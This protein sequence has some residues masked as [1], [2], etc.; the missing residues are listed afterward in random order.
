[1]PLVPF[2]SFL[3]SS[4]LEIGITWNMLMYLCL[5]MKHFTTLGDLKISGSNSTV[6]QYFPL[7]CISIVS[8]TVI[9]Y[10][11]LKAYSA[12]A[13]S[14][15]LSDSH[16]VFSWLISTSGSISIMYSLRWFAFL[17]MPILRS[18]IR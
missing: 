7:I 16:S 17:H 15:E 9:F 2:L 13:H 10:F 11:A 4:S 8:E 14:N 12:V 1:M 5:E 3:L 6:P 18:G